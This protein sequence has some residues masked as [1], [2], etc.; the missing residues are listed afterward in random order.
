MI[1]NAAYAIDT[2]I[3]DGTLGLEQI[4]HFRQYASIRHM[5][6]IL[7]AGNSKSRLRHLSSRK[8]FSPLGLTTSLPHNNAL[9]CCGILCR[10]RI[11]QHQAAEQCL[12]F[13]RWHTDM[14]PT[15][16]AAASAADTQRFEPLLAITAIACS[17]G[18][19]GSARRMRSVCRFAFNHKISVLIFSTR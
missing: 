10:I 6:L 2:S 16:L 13:G 3:P 9:K 17:G 14:H 12:C 11:D 15:F 5:E 19:E 8:P 4:D 1:T 7:S 18:I